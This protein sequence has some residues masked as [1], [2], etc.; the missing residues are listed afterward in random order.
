M[1]G[2]SGK[3]LRD[4]LGIKQGFSVVFLYAPLSYI[5]GL[6]D[7]DDIEIFPMVKKDHDFIHIFVKEKEII[8][9][10]IKKI[11]MGIKPNGMIWVSWP[12]S[13]RS[14]RSGQASVVTDVNENTIRDICLPL[15]LVDVKVA[16]IDETW[17]G[18][19]LVIRKKYR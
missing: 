16:A 5:V 9:E 7:I 1:V 11:M 2:Y 3:S 8:E 12:R 4:K 14:A 19:K 6:G 10:E 13:T 17:S 15:G 18:L